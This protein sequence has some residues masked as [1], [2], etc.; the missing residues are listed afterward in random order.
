M[1]WHVAVVQTRPRKGDYAYSLERLGGVMAQLD[2]DQEPLDIMVLPECALTGYFLQGG[3]A[4]VART[5]SELLAELLDLFRSRTRRDRPSMDVVVGFPERYQGR[6][7]NAALYA[8]LSHSD[9]E[10]QVR[11]VHRKFFLPTYGVFDESRYVNRGRHIDTFDAATGRA[12]I[13]I[14][15]DAWHS[16]TG[17]VLALKGAQVLYIP[18]ASPARG[19]TE[20]SVA[21]LSYWHRLARSIAEEHAIFVVTASL[22]GF[23][24]GKGFVG[25]SIVVGPTGEV[26]VEGPLGE[27]CVLRATLDLEEI[28]IARA[29]LPLLGDLETRLPD[30][31][32][33][34]TAAGI[35][36]E[37]GTWG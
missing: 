4:E 8:T 29:S 1:E 9:A 15:E 10:V 19:F 12:G 3:V 6:L 32:R 5:A 2:A 21:N 16:L 30:L 26:L 18:V 34:L 7:Y 11:H 37:I 20:D 14:C 24:G 27:E 13:L 31:I 28:P 23:E 33:E 36:A 22:V 35:P 25:S 17:T